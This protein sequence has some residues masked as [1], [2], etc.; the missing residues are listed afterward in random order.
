[1]WENLQG[2]KLYPDKVRA[3]CGDGEVIQPISLES[4]TEYAL[5][6]WK[7]E[8]YSRIIPSYMTT[9]REC[10]KLH[11]EDATDYDILNW[12]RIKEL[13]FNIAKDSLS[14]K[15]LLTRVKEALAASDYETASKLQIELQGKMAQLRIQYSKYRKNLF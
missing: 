13:R 1:M 6:Q 12:E 9:V 11:G 10:V 14:E 5:T 8:L 15:S 3:V 7:T 4:Y 2:F